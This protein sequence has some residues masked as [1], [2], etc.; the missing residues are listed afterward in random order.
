M[1]VCNGNWWGIEIL[2]REVVLGPNGACAITGPTGSGKSALALRSVIE[3]VLRGQRAEIWSLANDSRIHAIR[4]GAAGL[5]REN[6]SPTLHQ[7]HLLTTNS[8]SG[9]L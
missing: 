1:G 5:L 7:T 6:M 8:T 4:L 2:D 9:I 3:V